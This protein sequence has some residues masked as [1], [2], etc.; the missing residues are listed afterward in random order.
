MV[1]ITDG[2]ISKRLFDEIAHDVQRYLEGEYY[3]MRDLNQEVRI[4]HETG[5]YDG[6]S[7]AHHAIAER[8]ARRCFKQIYNP[9]AIRLGVV[10]DYEV[11]RFR[12]RRHTDVCPRI[13][14]DEEGA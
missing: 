5:S 7:Q 4:M 11:F 9:G 3:L 6:G 2:F 14:T 12:A 1:Q 8:Y 13:I 10:I